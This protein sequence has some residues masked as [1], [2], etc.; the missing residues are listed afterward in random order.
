MFVNYVLPQDQILPVQAPM[1]AAGQAKGL[2][3]AYL[4]FNHHHI[5]HHHVSKLSQVAPGQAHADA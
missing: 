5:L 3:N 4:V 1:L 2:C